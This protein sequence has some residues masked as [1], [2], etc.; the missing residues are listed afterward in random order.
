MYIDL[1]RENKLAWMEAETYSQER[2]EGLPATQFQFCIFTF[3]VMFQPTVSVSL[4]KESKLHN[5]AASNRALS[6]SAEH[7]ETAVPESKLKYG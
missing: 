7:P 1:K 4:V 6:W 3:L 2:Q 5:R